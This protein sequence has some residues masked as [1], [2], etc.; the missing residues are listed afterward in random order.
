VADHAEVP[1]KGFMVTGPDDREMVI[2]NLSQL[3][4]GRVITVEKVSR[5]TKQYLKLS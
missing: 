4:A 5:G 1:A 2:T 3:P